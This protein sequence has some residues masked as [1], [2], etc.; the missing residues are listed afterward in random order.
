MSAIA[1]K[2]NDLIS[3]NISEYLVEDVLVDL[4]TIMIDAGYIRKGNTYELKK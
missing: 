4:D 2:Y 3:S 1:Q